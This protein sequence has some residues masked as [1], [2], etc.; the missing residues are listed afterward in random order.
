MPEH[1]GQGG[2]GSA[3]HER[4]AQSVLDVTS[5]TVDTLTACAGHGVV[6]DF[7]RP[8]RFVS[9]KFAMEVSN[10]FLWCGLLLLM[11]VEREE[12]NFSIKRDSRETQRQF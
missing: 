10:S 12:G 5:V 1:K 3:W 4:A 7:F 6:E 9:Y 11:D 8:R 2:E